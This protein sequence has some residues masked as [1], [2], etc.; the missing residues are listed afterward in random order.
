MRKHDSFGGAG[1]ARGIE[2]VGE[3]VGGVDGFERAWGPII[4]NFDPSRVESVEF[5]RIANEDQ[6]RDRTGTGPGASKRF[7]EFGVN[8]DRLDARVGQDARAPSR[9]CQRI[10]GNVGGARAQNALDR[11]DGLDRF[12]QKETDSIAS[13]DVPAPQAG[14]EP[15]ARAR[16]SA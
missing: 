3:I 7:G 6:S 8:D 10:D 4:L 14:R 2:N 1:R 12:G 15:I 11:G 16:S 5:G 9:G 13:A